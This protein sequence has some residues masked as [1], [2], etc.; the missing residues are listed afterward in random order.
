MKT[1]FAYAASGLA[2][3]AIG[4]AIALAPAASAATLS[5]PIAPA[6]SFVMDGA[7]ADPL[8]PFGPEPQVPGRLGYVDS[9]HDEVNTTNGQ[10]DLPF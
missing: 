8:V 7:G 3:A 5:A 2:A 9:N 10:I 1:P 6:M 4:A